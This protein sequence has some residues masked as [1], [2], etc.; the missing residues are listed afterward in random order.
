MV[1]QADVTGLPTLIAAA[2]GLIVLLALI[3]RA[4]SGK[5]VLAGEP[6]PFRKND[7]VGLAM[8]AFGI[9]LGQQALG[10]LMIRPLLGTVA[11]V[12]AVSLGLVLLWFVRARVANERGPVG[13]RVSQGVIV[14]WAALPVVYG[15][16]FL[17]S[18]LSGSQEPQ[19]SVN[20]MIER[21]EGWQNMIV[22][23]A[24]VAPLLEEVAFRGLLYPALRQGIG[25]RGA[26]VVSAVI[27]G[28][29][30]GLLFMLPLALFGAAL[31]LLVERNGSVLSC[32][33]AHSLFNLLTVSQIVLA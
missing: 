24:L 17:V 12:V 19:E 1:A 4:V 13:R 27:F 31:A 8:L 6:E 7:P 3:A 33:V 11:L 18:K 29:A 16:A 26:V 28:A 2:S 10:T 20:Y 9:Y 25:V 22:F 14:V 5:P 21:K 23:A 32:V 15:A 30:H